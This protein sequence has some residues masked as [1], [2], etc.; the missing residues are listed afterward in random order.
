MTV[1]GC[2]SQDAM[3]SD[4]ALIRLCIPLR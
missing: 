2:Q 4:H 3:M 1:K